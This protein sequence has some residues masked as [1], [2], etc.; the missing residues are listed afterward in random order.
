[1][2]QGGGAEKNFDYLIPVVIEDW[3][4]CLEYVSVLMNLF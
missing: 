4:G 1:M 2:R 3:A